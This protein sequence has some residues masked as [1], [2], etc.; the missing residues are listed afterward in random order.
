MQQ[1][2]S[3]SPNRN[4]STD[5]PKLVGQM[6]CDLQVPENMIKG[7]SFLAKQHQERKE[8]A[9]KKREAAVE[10]AESALLQL[11][12]DLKQGKSETLV[13]FLQ[14]MS[15]F[16]SYSFN[17]QLLIAIQ[18]P[19]AT[20]VA[21]FHSWKKLGR[22]V[23]KGESGIRILAPM[24]GKAKN[25]S[26]DEELVDGQA[27][28]RVYGFRVVSVFDV[29]QT[30]GKPLPDIGTIDGDPGNK[31]NCLRNLIRSKGI[32][33]E[34]E[35]LNGPEGISRGGAIVIDT[36]LDAPNE[37]SVLVHELAHELLHREDRRENTD[38]TKRE[39]EAEAVAFVVC[40]A[41]GVDTSAR[42]SDY[43]QLYRGNS[44]VLAESLDFIRATAADIISDLK[45][46]NDVR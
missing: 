36:G 31:L 24:I 42:S 21:G 12:N 33:L 44:A 4:S 32:S 39:T 7:E 1:R 25:E 11:E 14:T 27:T 23:K 40:H 37:F 18:N 22:F 2:T 17:N 41:F 30:D 29:S 38:K 43:I 45:K 34:Y 15:T 6:L 28:K 5:G 20:R 19:E 3:T 9:Q 35:K 16:H 8:K 10:L 46:N 13:E 26:T